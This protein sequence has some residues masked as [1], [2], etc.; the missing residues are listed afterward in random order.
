MTR[1]SLKTLGPGKKCQYELVFLVV[2]RK[3]IR[4]KQR[5]LFLQLFFPLGKKPLAAKAN[6]LF[7]ITVYHQ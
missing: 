6:I 1:K 2:E 3:I 5:F 4:R 7:I